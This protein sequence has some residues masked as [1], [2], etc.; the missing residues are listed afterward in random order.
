MGKLGKESLVTWSSDYEII[1][2]KG[3]TKYFRPKVI[4]YI[5]LLVGISV[6]LGMMG[7]KKEHMLLNIN[8]ENR[9][10]STKVMPDGKVKVNNSYVFLLQNTEL[11]TMKFYFDILTPKGME[12]K[13]IIARPTKAFTAQPG[14]KKKKI[15][16]LSTTE[17]LVNNPIKDTVIP[18]TIHAYALDK[19]GTK[20]EKIS[21]FRKS[22]FIYPKESVLKSSK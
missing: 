19:N 4:V 15:V 8:K 14:V 20:S 18:I 17:V 13:I 5:A 16:T 1:D 3:K 11:E 21:V 22:S 10:Y 7:S 9:L 6:I 2:Q 12:G